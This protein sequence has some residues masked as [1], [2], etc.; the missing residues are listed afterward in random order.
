MVNDNGKQKSSGS[1]IAPV[2]D[3]WRKKI[4]FYFHEVLD[5]NNDGIVNHLDLEIFKTLYK[6]MKHL[7]ADSPVLVRFCE[8][9]DTWFK[10]IMLAD[11]KSGKEACITAQEFSAYCELVRKELYGRK[12]L[13]DALQYMKDY[14]DALFHILDVDCDGFITK[15]DYVVAYAEFEDEQSREQYWKKICECAQVP[16]NDYK[17][18]KSVFIEFCIEFLV[19]TSPNE[20]GNWLFGVFDE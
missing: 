4:N 19:S 20:K 17:I 12:H 8:F 9:L 2:N 15:N 16:P 3:F 10:A 6:Q 7:S 13:P 11:Q 18:D 5:V 14:I 1:T